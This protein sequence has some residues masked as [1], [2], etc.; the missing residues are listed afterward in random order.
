MVLNPGSSSVRPGR[1]PFFAYWN[2]GAGTM[3]IFDLRLASADDAGAGGLA[4]GS[5]A[6]CAG[7]VCASSLGGPIL[8]GSGFASGAAGATTVEA[9]PVSPGEGPVLGSGLGAGGAGSSGF[10]ASRGA[11]G[12]GGAA[13][14]GASAGPAVADGVLRAVAT[15]ADCGLGFFDTDPDPGPLN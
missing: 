8:T 11:G 15:V 5:G 13:T 9:S 4:V 12:R 6:E 1:V 2:S 10:A 7:C 3:L 14:A